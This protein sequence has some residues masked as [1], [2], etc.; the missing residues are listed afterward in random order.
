METKDNV[1]LPDKTTGLTI[2]G[3]GLL[4]GFTAANFMHERKVAECDEIAAAYLDYNKAQRALVFAECFNP[5][6][7]RLRP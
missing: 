3:I 1:R 2:L 4:V 7:Y 5:K 6:K